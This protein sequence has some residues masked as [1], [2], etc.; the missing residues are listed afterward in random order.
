MNRLRK[1]WRDHIVPLWSEFKWMILLLMG[2]TGLGLGYI[3]FTKHALSLGEDLTPLDSIYRTLGLISMNT[4][5]V[6]GPVSWEL[7][8]ARFLLPVT[9]AWTALLAFATLFMRQTELIR[10]WF[11]RDHVVICGLGRKGLQLAGQFMDQ[12]YPVVVIEADDEN[13][14]VESVRASGAIVLQGNATDPTL[15]K[16]A[17]I[18]RAKYLLSVM[19]DDGRNA[20]VA[21]HARRLSRGRRHNPLTCVI[22]IF[23]SQL[24]HLLR[25]KELDAHTNSGFRLQLFN[26]FERGARRML[27]DNPPWEEDEKQGLIH[28][29]VVGLGKLGQSLLLELACQ[30][31]W[32]HDNQHGGL[33]ISVIDLDVD[34]KL[35]TLRVRYPRLGQTIDIHPLSMDVRSVDLNAE[36]SHF[37]KNGTNELNVIYIC[38]DDESLCLHTGLTLRQQLKDGRIPIVLRMAEGEGLSQLL[39]DGNLDRRSHADLRV[40]NLLD[41]TCT[42]DIITK[43]TH[44]LL[45]QHL[46][47]SYLQGLEQ[48]ADTTVK[49]SAPPPWADLPEEEKEKNRRQAD[50][51]LLVLREAGYCVEPLWDWGAAALTFEENTSDVD[52]EVT[53]MAKKEHELWCEEQR[54]N[55]WRHGPRKNP[56]AKTHPDLVD[57]QDLPETEREKNKAYIRELPGILAWAGFQIVRERAIA[58]NPTALPDCG[59]QD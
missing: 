33:R 43:G 28:V 59:E 19:G 36:H 31:R 5:A 20:Q 52:D 41:E 37:M 47:A 21:V 48:T 2:S 42:V 32:M 18:E 14:W 39:R 54:T 45:G 23:D 46:Y 29:L 17:R 30:W 27:Q 53:R 11:M 13:D 24:Y 10:L 22:H 7:Q 35:E 8:I 16:K 26:I 12:G 40:L 34:Q 49:D 9:A 15:L 4:G 6:P 57:W 58:Q 3:G 25:E 44:E 51:M 55:G 50:R 56:A 1:A 38:F